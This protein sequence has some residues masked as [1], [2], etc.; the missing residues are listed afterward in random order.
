MIVNNA[1]HAKAD[2]IGTEA[3][4]V[5]NEAADAKADPVGI[6]ATIVKNETD[7]M[8]GWVAAIFNVAGGSCRS[9]S[10]SW[11]QIRV[12]SLQSPK[13]QRATQSGI[14]ILVLIPKVVVYRFWILAGS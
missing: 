1:I 11:R 7:A 13:T 14:H 9:M 5:N 2:R 3:M 12:W 10:R 4:I 8:A 6:N